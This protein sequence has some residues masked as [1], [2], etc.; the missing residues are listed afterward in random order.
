MSLNIVKLITKAFFKIGLRYPSCFLCKAANVIS[1][2]S[3]PRSYITKSKWT[4]LPV[5][6][7]KGS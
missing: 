1:V 5:L 2:E 4:A 6:R 3:D 7:I